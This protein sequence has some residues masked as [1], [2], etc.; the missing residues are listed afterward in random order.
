MRLARRAEQAAPALRLPSQGLALPAGVVA[1]VACLALHM[2]PIPSAAAEAA[3]VA[4]AVT[5]K[6]FSPQQGLPIRA[7]AVAL[8]GLALQAE[9]KS[10]KQE[11][12]AS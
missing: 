12:P 4:P 9:T 8:A 1:A 11:A 2:A 5:V 6:Q 7:A 3:G 10:A